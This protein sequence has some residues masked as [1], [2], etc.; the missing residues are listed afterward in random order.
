MQMDIY[1][2]SS[3]VRHLVY[4]GLLY[5]KLLQVKEEGYVID[6]VQNKGYR[7]TEYPDIITDTEIRSLLIKDSAILKSKADTEQGR[8]A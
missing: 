2:D 5:G 7:I 3:C 4:Q 8:E 1:Q 6:S